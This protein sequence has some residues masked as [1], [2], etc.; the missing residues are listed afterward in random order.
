M[1]Y[2][3]FMSVEL[4]SEDLIRYDGTLIDECTTICKIGI[5]LEDAVPVL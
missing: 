5:F 4:V 2:R 1:Y 3:L